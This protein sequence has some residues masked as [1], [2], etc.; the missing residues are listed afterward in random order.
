MSAAQ[1][2]GSG[3]VAG[4]DGEKIEAVRFFA[5]VRVVDDGERGVLARGER[6]RERVEVAGVGDSEPEQDGLIDG[7]VRGR[8]E[9]AVVEQFRGGDGE[10]RGVRRVRIEEVEVLQVEPAAV[11]SGA[12][13]A[14]DEAERLRYAEGELQERYELRVEGAEPEEAGDEEQQRKLRRV[15]RRPRD[16]E[17]IENEQM[18]SDLPEYLR[19]GVGDVQRVRPLPALEAVRG[20][21]PHEPL[22]A[23]RRV[24][25]AEEERQGVAAAPED[26]LEVLPV[27]VTHE[28][29]VA[30]KEALH[31]PIAA[32]PPVVRSDAGLLDG[33]KV[34]AAAEPRNLRVGNVRRALHTLRRCNYPHRE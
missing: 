13:A 34:R 20:G 28:E 6:L 4:I 25:G 26:F 14:A 2:K 18:E 33:G 31:G 19:H 23:E 9:V 27:V 3:A 17:R 32:T 24:R 5:E 16:G 15:D 30:R 29:D 10:D 7:G 21:L 8:A 11:E 12:L 1:G 22:Y